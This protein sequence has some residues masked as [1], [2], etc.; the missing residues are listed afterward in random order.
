M[1]ETVVCEPEGLDDTLAT[2]LFEVLVDCWLGE[3]GIYELSVQEV[4]DIE[5]AEL[6]IGA[7]ELEGSK[8]DELDSELCDV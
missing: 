5:V 1:A 4:C 7:T 3:R 8:S 2:V 6:G